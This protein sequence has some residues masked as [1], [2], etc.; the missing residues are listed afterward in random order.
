MSVAPR[1]L[2]LRE[3]S[4]NAVTWLEDET[5]VSVFMETK[6]KLAI[7]CPT[8]LCKYVVG[9]LVMQKH[10]SCPKKHDGSPMCMEGPR[11]T[12]PAIMPTELK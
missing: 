2:P 10:C 8:D 11:F 1:L 3:L 12:H 7:T 9:F 4:K 5:V 6:A